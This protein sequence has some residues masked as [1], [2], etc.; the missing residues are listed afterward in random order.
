MHNF[1]GYFSGTFQDQSDIPGPG[2]FKKKTTG[3]TFQGDV[4]TLKN[5][6]FGSVK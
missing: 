6:Q 5:V 4:G 2:I 1:Q 3:L